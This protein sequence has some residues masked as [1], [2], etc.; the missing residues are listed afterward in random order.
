MKYIYIYI[1]ISNH[2]LYFVWNVIIRPYPD[3]NGIMTWK[4][5]HKPLFYIDV[6]SYPCSN[7]H[8][9]LADQDS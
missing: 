9:G 5:K 4:G 7:P 6:I 2:G 1:Y 3:F 8:A